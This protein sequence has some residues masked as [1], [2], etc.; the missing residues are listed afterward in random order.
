VATGRHILHPHPLLSS[1]AGCRRDPAGVAGPGHHTSGVSFSH[2]PEALGPNPTSHRDQG[3]PT[4]GLQGMP[5][6]ADTQNVRP[7]P[8]GQ[9]SVLGSVAENGAHGHALLAA[10]PHARQ[11]DVGLSHAQQQGEWLLHILI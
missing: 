10:L 11:D 2:N 5:A 6:D 1:A 4:A 9:V 7:G 8:E 3:A